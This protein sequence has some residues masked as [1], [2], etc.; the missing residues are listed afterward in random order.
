MLLV[1]PLTAVGISAAYL[2]GRTEAVNRIRV[3]SGTISVREEFD[4][5][6]KQEVGDNAFKKRVQIE[7]IGD[8]DCF[9]RVFMDF[10][11]SQVR[12]L[13]KISPDEANW[14][15]VSEYQS[16]GFSGLPENWIY[17]PESEDQLLGGYF[18]YTAPL[19]AGELTKP[20]MERILV[21]Y[22][23]AAQIQDFDILVAADSV[24]TWINMEN[25]DGSF[26]AKDVSNMSGGWK[27]AWIEYME[28]R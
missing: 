11:D 19:K 5:P 27:T 9:V 3:G 22:A 26:T 18:Y 7:N 16:P 28:R 25:G 6:K 24:Q 2:A 15:R 14:Y 4:P 10:S 20:L 8:T 23:S 12:E 1:L 21:S 13:A 17:I